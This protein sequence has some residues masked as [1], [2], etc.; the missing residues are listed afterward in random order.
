MEE[1]NSLT[2]GARGPHK[3]GGVS[4]SSIPNELV[5]V[6]HITLQRIGCHDFENLVGQKDGE[7]QIYW[8]SRKK[9]GRSKED[10]SLGLRSFEM[11]N[12]VVLAK[13]GWR[14]IMELNSLWVSM[15]KA[16]YFP[17][18][19]FLNTK[20]GGIAFWAWSNLLV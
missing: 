6:S 15:L 14:L 19:S 4:N 20:W 18:C 9:L 3:G 12:D 13:Q 2:S 10:G 5:Q 8:L 1:I 16:R 17:N 11:F 7:N